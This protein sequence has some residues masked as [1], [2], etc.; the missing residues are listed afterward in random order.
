MTT[1]YMMCNFNHVID[2]CAFFYILG[3]GVGCVGAHTKNNGVH[4]WKVSW[5]NTYLFGTMDQPLD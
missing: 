1:K 3:R 4:I 5:P 2:T